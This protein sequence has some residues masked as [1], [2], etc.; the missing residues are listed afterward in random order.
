MVKRAFTN[1]KEPANDQ[2]HVSQP[3]E[4]IHS[5]LCMVSLMYECDSWTLLHKRTEAQLAA[6]EMGC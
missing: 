4:E 1:K 6:M 2:K 3:K 5:V